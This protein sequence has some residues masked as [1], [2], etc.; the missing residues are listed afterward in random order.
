MDKYK[1]LVV[2]LTLQLSRISEPRYI[3]LLP[4]SPLHFCCSSF[5][6]KAFKSADLK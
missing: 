1:L 5:F 3:L 6:L 4:L 2:L